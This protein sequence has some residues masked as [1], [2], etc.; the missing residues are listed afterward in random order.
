V[1]SG[2]LRAPPPALSAFHAPY[3]ALTIDL[4]HLQVTELAATQPCAIERH[5]HRAVEEVLGPRDQASDFLRTQ[6]GRQPA[7]TLRRRQVLLQRA[8]LQDPDIEEAQRGDVEPHR[9]DGELSLLEQVRLIPPE[10]IG[11]E[12][13]EAP[14]GMLEAT[15]IEGVQIGLDGRRGVVPSHELVVHALQQCGHRQHLLRHTLRCYESPDCPSAA[16]PAA[17]FWSRSADRWMSCGR[18]RFPESVSLRGPTSAHVYF[19]VYEVTAR[20]GA[21]RM[22]VPGHRHQP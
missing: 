20:I 5:Q 2:G 16:A 12:L 15:G 4:A 3:H 8:P 7:M 19:G 14:T 21:G 13:I 18:P 17:S 1:R 11:P 10:I 9:T 6:N 22:G